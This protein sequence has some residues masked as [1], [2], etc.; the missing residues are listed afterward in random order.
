MSSPTTVR[1]R[2]C[3]AIMLFLIALLTSLP[4]RAQAPAANS[5][6]AREAELDAAFAAAA[7]AG[8]RGP[9][10]VTLRDQASLGIPPDQMFVPQREAA[11]ILR[12]FGNTTKDDSLDGIVLGVTPD[13]GGWI[14]VVRYVKEGYIKDDE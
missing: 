2:A 1:L 14:V 5:E 13:N 6:A 11:R 12:A 4:A 7:Q 3:G 8:T 10:K 9:A